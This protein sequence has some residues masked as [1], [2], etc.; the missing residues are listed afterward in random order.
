MKND[1]LI[2]DVISP[3]K[4]S[5]TKVQE[6]LD[7][8]ESDTIHLR[9]NTPGGA[10]TEGIA[11]ET[12]LKRSG[13]KIITHIDGIAA[14]MGF[15]LF[16]L[17][18]ERYVNSKSTGMIHNAEGGIKGT[19]DQ[20]EQYGKY[21]T[22][23]NNAYA[24]LVSERTGKSEEEVKALMTAQTWYI[25]AELIN[26]GFATHM[27]SVQFDVA[28]LISEF[29]DNFQKTPGSLIA[30]NNNQTDEQMLKAEL[31]KVVELKAD[32]EDT[33]FVQKVQSLQ[34]RAELVSGLEAK[35]TDLTGKLSGYKTQV[36][37]LQTKLEAYEVDKVTAEVCEKENVKLSAEHQDAFTRRAKRYHEATDETVKA[38]LKAD[39]HTY[40]RLNG[41]P[42]GA[43]P[44]LTGQANG[45]RQDGNAEE[46]L[47]ARVLSIQAE[48]KKSGKD[49]S[50]P[51]A[52]QLAMEAK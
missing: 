38:D 50:Y 13:K 2:Y 47:N 12:V 18:D 34:S 49:L 6:Q 20:I 1:I 40:A 24:R 43:D 23:H 16:M 29:S 14:S 8:I 44:T 37:D 26:N 39:L 28:A 45:N 3:D 35:V 5:A 33:L 15:Y 27:E 31:A 36:T 42:V 30:V 46:Q 7:K 22:S 48:A 17:G 21:V 19:G 51:E 52:L 41:V 25:G 9:L 4:V 10:V 32:A 11:I